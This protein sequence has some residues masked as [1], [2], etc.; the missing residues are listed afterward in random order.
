MKEQITNVKE[1]LTNLNNNITNFVEV[2]D[3][4][5]DKKQLNIY[6]DSI[7]EM[8]KEIRDLIGSPNSRKN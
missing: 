8:T 7:W 4:A 2:L 1:Q 6:L 3:Y 5:K